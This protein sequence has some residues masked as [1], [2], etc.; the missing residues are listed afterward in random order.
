MLAKNSERHTAR[1]A[2]D[3]DY[4]E[5]IRERQR[6]RRAAPECRERENTRRR[7][8]TATDPAYRDK[9]HASYGRWAA[10]NPDKVFIRAQRSSETK[11]RRRI[12]EQF[13]EVAEAVQDVA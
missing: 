3:P 10:A 2:S 9:T 4:R 12:E 6:K 1:Y 11:R 13:P 7:E 5:S 8:R